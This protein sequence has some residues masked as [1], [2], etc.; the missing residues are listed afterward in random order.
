[1]QTGNFPVGE[2]D[3]RREHADNE[4]AECGCE[5]RI[6]LLLQGAC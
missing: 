2:I 5:R 1:L 4:P 3:A 6:A